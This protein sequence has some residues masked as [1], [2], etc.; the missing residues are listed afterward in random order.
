MDKGTGSFQE[1]IQMANRY[2]KRCSLLIIRVRQIQTTV[3]YHCTPVARANI[4][5]TRVCQGC[6][7]MDK[8]KLSYTVGGIHIGV[9]TMENSIKA[10][11]AF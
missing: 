8:G 2:M 4:R 6:K 11:K 7:D 3:R 10:L 9:A 5:K 1:D